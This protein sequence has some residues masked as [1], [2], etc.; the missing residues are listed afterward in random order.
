MSAEFATVPIGDLSLGTVL[1]SPI[2]DPQQPSTKLLGLGIEIDVDF[3]EKLQS[4]GVSDVIVSKRDLAAMHAGTPQGVRRQASDHTYSTTPKV[5]ALSR[6]M[7]G[8]I[9]DGELETDFVGDQVQRFEQRTDRYDEEQLNHEVKRREQQVS[10]VDGLF[11][12]LVQG[13]A[14]NSEQLDDVCRDSIK[15]IISDKDLFLCLGLNPFDA[16]YPARHSLH[17]STVAVSIGVVLG[18]DDESLAD[19]GTG[20]LIHDVGMLKLDKGVYK[21]KRK[22][23]PRELTVLAEHPLRTLEALECPGVKISRVARI[24]A[25]QIHERCNG[26]GYPRGRTGDEIHGLAKIAAVADAYVG[27]V[28]NRSH[29]RGLM[30]YFAIEKILRDIPQGLFDSK[31]VRGLL[32]AVSL[33]PIGSFAELNDGSVCRVVRSMGEDYMSPIVELWNEKHKQFEPDLL[34]LAEERD[35][36]IKR[37]MH[38]PQAA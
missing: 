8:E 15:S 19:L 5:T 12:N 10:Y 34:N 31:A 4:R 6:Q 38:A 2:F 14:A 9:S 3:L 26:T 18:L 11:E 24:V 20:C 32:H 22:L 35:K 13:A 7:D 29:R 33:F 21:A 25:Y 37:A 23:N 27:L 28:S 1:T 36:R 30:P 17:V 16:D